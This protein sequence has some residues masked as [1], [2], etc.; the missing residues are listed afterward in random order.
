MILVFTI[1]DEKATQWHDFWKA[2]PESDEPL[3]RFGFKMWVRGLYEDEHRI[4]KECI[5]RMRYVKQV[6]RDEERALRR[7]PTAA[8]KECKSSRAP[9]N[10]MKSFDRLDTMITQMIKQV[11]I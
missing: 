1:R 9:L 4:V 5:E 10:A 6:L 3:G 7:T 11:K 2:R 8:M